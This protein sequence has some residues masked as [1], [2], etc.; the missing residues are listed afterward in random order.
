MPK[1]YFV[2]F[3]T[4]PEVD[5]RKCAVGIGCA[6]QIASDGHTVDAFFAAHAVRL[7]HTDYIDNLDEAAGQASGSCRAMLDSLIGQARG[8]HCSTGSQE[9][10]GVT[11]DNAGAILVPGLDVQWSGPS[12]VSA[13]S[14]SADT[15]LSF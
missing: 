13:L 7:L 6:S 8:V 14:A 11:P 15:C 2:M 5:P 4:D 12:G 10:V 1:T 9:L 3:S